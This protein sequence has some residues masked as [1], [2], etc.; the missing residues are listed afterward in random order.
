MSPA[1][2]A[3]PQSAGRQPWRSLVLYIG[4]AALVIPTTLSLGSQA[5]SREY[6]AHG[7]IVLITGLW[8]FWRERQELLAT[9]VPG[10]LWL[11]AAGMLFS[12]AAYV[13]GRAYE[14][15]SVEAAGIYGICVSILYSRVGFRALIRN[16]FPLLYLGFAI[17]PPLWFI[18][19]IT[20]P[21]KLLVSAVATGI[22]SAAGIP[23]FREGV[24]LIVAQYSLLV[25]DAC[26]GLNSLTGLTAISLFYIYLLRR[27]SWRYS[28]V[29]ALMVLPI[30][31]IAN[32][33]RIMI[34]VLLTYFFGNAVG[35]GF[36]H[37]TAG[38]LLF[39]TSLLLVFAID[40]LMSR[41][42]PVRTQA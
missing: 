39:A 32:I 1:A 41:F 5:W 11:T 28:L 6:G 23:I 2:A 16:W 25:E 38:M 24:T 34:L 30:A 18:D 21:L 17:P 20:A 31:V 22:L 8:L 14:F 7:P 29:L 26:S 4:L 9:A 19:D 42:W 35:Q 13:F 12:I 27:A 36:L 40:K 3:P 37:E 10:N 15:I 33:I